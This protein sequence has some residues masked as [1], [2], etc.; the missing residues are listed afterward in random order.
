M[1]IFF[2]DQILVRCPVADSENILCKY[3]VI[4]VHTM[5]ALY[6]LIETQ[7]LAEML[8]ERQGLLHIL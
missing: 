3:K 5:D 4:L 1:L 8:L 7:A 6:V 2:V